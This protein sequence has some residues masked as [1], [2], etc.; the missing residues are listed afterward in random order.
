[1]FL[2]LRLIKRQLLTYSLQLG[3]I[4]TAI[5]MA[6]CSILT[7]IAHEFLTFIQVKTTVIGAT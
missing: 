1:M 5:C 6:L 2:Y 3:N 7:Q 4:L